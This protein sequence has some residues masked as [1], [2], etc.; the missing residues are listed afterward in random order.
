VEHID[1]AAER[2]DFVVR[3]MGLAAARTEHQTD[4]P[5]D[6]IDSAG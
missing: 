2:I 6:H 3:D 1:L 5:A 4:L